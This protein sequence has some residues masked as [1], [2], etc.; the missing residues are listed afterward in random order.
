[1][2][3]E[4]RP[5]LRAADALA[6]RLTYA[7][8]IIAAAGDAPTNSA[9]VRGF[10]YVAQGSEKFWEIGLDEATITVRFGRI[11]TNGATQTKDLGTEGRARW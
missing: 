5:V 4:T 1:M 7:D 10:E 3:P 9:P 8:L 2:P 6:G 11:G